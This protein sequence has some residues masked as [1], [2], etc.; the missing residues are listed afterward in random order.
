MRYFSLILKVFGLIFFFIC[1]FSYFLLSEIINPRVKNIDGNYQAIVILS[2]NLNRARYASMIFKER[3]SSKILLSKEN[4]RLNLISPDEV[5]RTYQLYVSVLLENGIKRDQIQ[6]L[7]EDNHSTF[8]EISSLASYLQL[9]NERVLVVTDRYHANR[10]KIIAEH[11]NILQ[12]INLYLIDADDK[13]HLIQSYILE[14]FKTINFY[15]F[16]F[17]FDLFKYLDFVKN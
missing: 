14:Y 4:R 8:D 15:L 12:N 5:M 2:G 6:F 10:V 17:G 16:L 11:L 13:K 1:I 9:N 3:E 7:G